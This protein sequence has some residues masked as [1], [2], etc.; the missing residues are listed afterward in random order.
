MSVIALTTAQLT[1]C[2]GGSTSSGSKGTPHA[3][4][5]GAASDTPCLRACA[6]FEHSCGNADC[7]NDCDAIELAYQAARCPV[8]SKAHFDCVASL[9]S[10]DFDCA[11]GSTSS[12][13]DEIM[14]ETRLAK[15]S[16]EYEAFAICSK[17]KGEDCAPEPTFDA[18][19][20]ALDSGHPHFRYCKLDVPSPTDCVAYSSE[21]AGW[22]CCK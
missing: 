20:G 14:S 2:C 8:E 9:S 22:Y 13:I 11:N 10:D 19:C 12:A 4:T 5:A 6:N 17:T 7:T 3:N 18:S 1:L 16:A 21:L 15:C